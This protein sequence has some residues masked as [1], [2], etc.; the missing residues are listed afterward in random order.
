MDVYMN[1][2]VDY[3]WKCAQLMDSD[4]VLILLSI[5][6]IFDRPDFLAYY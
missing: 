2:Y 4:S 3:T 6:F 5:D 1:I